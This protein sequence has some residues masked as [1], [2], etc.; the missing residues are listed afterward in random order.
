MNKPKSRGRDQ[1][2][3]KNASL[4]SSPR[5]VYPFSGL[6]A[7]D[8]MKLGLIL[9]VIDPSIGGV[10]MMGHR[11]TGKSTAVRAL[12]DLLPEI[13]VVRGCL[14]N[15]DPAALDEACR[16]CAARFAATEK[17]PRERMPVPVIDLPLG[18]TE[19]RV[20]GA[21]DIERALKGGDKVF[22]PGLLARANR[23]FL[24]IDE[25][26]LLEDHLVDLLLDVAVTGRNQ[27]ERENIS[28]EHPA[29]FVL[30]GSGNPE[31][32]ELR[33]QLLDRFGLYV[34]VSTENDPERRLEIVQKRDAFER[35]P[36]K[37]RAAVEG[38]QEELRRRIAR[39]RKA[40]V[41][42]KIGPSLLRQ[43][44]QLCCDLKIDGHRGEL[45]IMRA[46]RALVAFE[47]RKTAREDD[48][49]RVAAMS[50]RHRMRRDA[51]DETAS[52]ARIERAM[53]KVFSRERR[54]NMSRDNDDGG[55]AKTDDSRGGSQRE[56]KSQTLSP[57]ARDGK[58]PGAETEIPSPPAVDA[59]LPS[60]PPGKQ[61]RRAI[62]KLSLSRCRD[63]AG[64]RSQSNSR[65]GRYARSV[66]WKSVGARIALDATLRE[67]V[68]LERSPDVTAA[69][70][71][72]QFA[73]KQGRL[74]IFV[75]DASGSMALNRINHAK[76]AVYRLLQQ[77]YINRD[78]LAI[79]ALKG[80]KAEVVLPPSRS[81]LLARRA[82]D[83]LSVGGGTPLSAGL[84]CAL[85]L[86]KQAAQ[87]EPA[88]VA[89]LLFTDGGANVPLLAGV[90]SD[91]RSRQ[92]QI[93]REVSSLGSKLRSAGVHSVV[94]KTHQG[95]SSNGDTQTIAN[96][97]GA[98]LVQLAPGG[99]S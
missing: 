87:Q 66:S 9:N 67:F 81:V 85:E 96:L 19:D 16:D 33:P 1:Q 59:T 28:I 26:N 88:E 72:K 49:R 97:L 94:V 37:F 89:L 35:A 90:Y 34:E 23:G 77:S 13:W 4:R 2:V 92:I 44:V 11:G 79:V 48:V 27:I 62:E 12:A 50:L 20:C 43:I 75:I 40:F 65:H 15:C 39:A 58:A 78:K 3:R 25:V 46:T 74:F 42:V 86:A 38:G 56:S 60:L 57:M 80:T 99:S 10:L 64:A 70:R 69:I 8:E 98:Q 82:L 83:S 54:P 68:R 91:R 95:F 7:Q 51:L 47:G 45:T 6:V 73:R 30:I 63:G 14:Y 32:G 31:E 36:E 41:E 71:Y 21:I 24:Y 29:R 76:G 53:D 93:E 17:L 52:S 84:A 22:E 18:A 61:T 5:R 55:A